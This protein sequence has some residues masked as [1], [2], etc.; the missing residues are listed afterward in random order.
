M[1]QNLIIFFDK[2]KKKIM[3]MIILSPLADI[4]SCFK[5]K[6]SLIFDTFFRKQDLIM[7]FCFSSKCILI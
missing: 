3:N 2:T 7:S 6:K 1:Y 5:K 4:C